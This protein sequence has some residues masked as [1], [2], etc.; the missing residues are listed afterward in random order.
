VSGSEPLIRTIA[1]VEAFE[2]IPLEE[3]SDAWTLPEVVARGA[4]LNPAAAARARIV[5]A[6]SD[7]SRNAAAEDQVTTI[8][9]RHTMAYD[10][11][12]RI[13]PGSVKEELPG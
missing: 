3:R 4:A 9:S 12:W 5:L 7:C 1:D 13:Q 2:R 6:S 10:V 11:V 8:M